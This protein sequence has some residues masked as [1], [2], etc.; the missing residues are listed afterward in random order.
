MTEVFATENI[1]GVNLNYDDDFETLKDEVGKIGNLDY[2]L[3]SRTSFKILREK[4]KDIRVFSFLGFALL[5]RE[6]W[7]GFSDVYEA[8]AILS[9][10]NFDSLFPDRIRAKESALKWL[11]ENRFM[12][13]VSTKKPESAAHDHITRLSG[14]LSKIKIITESKFPNSKVFPEDFYRTVKSWEIV[15]KPEPVKSPLL[16]QLEQKSEKPSVLN[17]APVQ[18]AASFETTKQACALTK[19]AASFLIQKEPCNPAGYR[20]MRCIRWD[21]IEKAP[22]SDGGKTLITGPTSQQR[23]FFE[24]IVAKENWKTVLEA[25]ESTFAGSAN[26]LWLDLQRIA[27]T[28]CEKLGAEYLF[29]KNAIIGETLLLVKRIPQILSLR[30]SDGSPFCEITTKDFFSSLQND[31]FCQGKSKNANEDSRWF[32]KER[33]ET[34]KIFTEKG[35]LAALDYLQTKTKTSGNERKK[36]IRNMTAASI[37]IKGSQPEIAVSLLE[38]LDEKAQEHGLVKWEPDLVCDL[39]LELIYAYKTCRTRKNSNQS[40]LSEKIN[41]TLC[42]LS[43]IDAVR[44][45]SINQ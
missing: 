31:H 8:L 40:V 23:L 13:L 45:C 44:A 39:L 35:Y 4:S 17:S 7:E 34:E 11:S 24:N 22:P 37:L 25:A 36:F 29:V 28:A 10:R 16:Q 14:S 12:E 32:E 26:H 43:R 15:C 2:D 6:D 9:E 3:I 20:L 33:E 27:A 18:H 42:K 38:S 30:F 21:Q 19:T 1:F 5:R 41:S